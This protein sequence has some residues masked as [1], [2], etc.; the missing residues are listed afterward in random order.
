M[1]RIPVWSWAALG[2]VAVLVLGAAACNSSIDDPDVSDAI[3]SVASY[4]PSTACIDVDGSLD[5]T[6]GTT[7]YT[8]AAQT[9]VFESRVRGTGGDSV[10]LDVILTSVDVSYTMTDPGLV[11][12][13][14]TTS[15]G[16]VTVPAGGTGTL[17]TFRTVPVGYIGPGAEF[18]SAGRQGTAKLVFHGKDAGGNPVTVTGTAAIGTYTACDGL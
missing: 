15:I 12:A 3:V 6:A 8:D 5:E 11:P 1:K 2:A 17:L 16:A 18:S 4:V 9:L 10:W 13:P 7:T 14:F